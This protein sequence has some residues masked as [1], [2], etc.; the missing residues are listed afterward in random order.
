MFT[1]FLIILFA[2]LP[3]LSIQIGFIQPLT[4]FAPTFVNTKLPSI[5]NFHFSLSSGLSDDAYLRVRFPNYTTLGTPTCLFSVNAPRATN[6]VACS[7]IQDSVYIQ[8][9]VEIFPEDEIRASI[10]LP[11]TIPNL[12]GYTQL[13]ELSTVSSTD[14]N[15]AIIYDSNPGYGNLLWG[16]HYLVGQLFLEVLSFGTPATR[17]LQGASNDIQ[18]YIR[19]NKAFSAKL[20]RVL[21]VLDMPWKFGNAAVSTLKS[22]LFDVAEGLREP[23]D[24]YTP[25]VVSSINIVNDYV[26]EIYFEGTFPAGREFIMTIT[27]IINPI[28]ISQGKIKFYST[29]YTS[30][31]ALEANENTVLFTAENTIPITNSL[32]FGAPFIGPVKLY[33]N[34]EQYIK[35]SFPLDTKIQ[36]G[37]TLKYTFAPDNTPIPGTFYIAPTVQAQDGTN[38]QYTYGTDSITLT[39]LGELVSGETITIQTKMKFSR[40]QPVFYTTVSILVEGIVVKFGQSTNLPLASNANSLVTYIR[41]TGSE[42]SVIIIDSPPQI[43]FRLATTSRVSAA[44]SVLTIYT[45]QFI[46]DSGSMTCA[47]SSGVSFSTCSLTNSGGYS[48]FTLQSASGANAFPVSSTVDIIISGLNIIRASDHN[49]GI[50][51]FYLRLDKDGTGTQVQDLMVFAFVR[52][53]R[54]LLTNF[55]QYHIMNV[56]SNTLNNFPG[57]MRMFGTSTALSAIT[58]TSSQNLIITVYGFVTLAN[59][60][61]VTNEGEFPCGGSLEISCKLVKGNPTTVQSNPLDWD[62]VIITISSNALT[63]AFN[64]YIPQYFVNNSPQI[65]EFLVGTYDRNTR[66][67]ENLY[68]ENLY[69]ANPW[70]PTTFATGT[71]TSNNPNLYIDLSLQRAGVMVPT[72]LSMFFST[73]NT[74]TAY[75]FNTGAQYGAATVLVTAWEFW[76]K[77]STLLSPA[78]PLSVSAQDATV[79]LRFTTGDGSEMNAVIWPM[80]GSADPPKVFQV[81]Q[82]EMPYSLDIPDYVMYV[83]GRN[84]D[85]LYY[86]SLINTGRN[87]LSVNAITQITFNCAQMVRN[88]LN[89]FCTIQFT[90]NAKI[91]RQSKIKVKFSNAFV[92]IFGC[93]LSYESAPSVT[94][95]LTS[96]EFSCSSNLDEIQLSFNLKDRLPVTSYRFS[97]YGFDHGS[98]SS[99]SFIFNIWD[100]SYGFILEQATVN[101]FLELTIPDVITIDSMTYDYSNL[102]SISNFNLRFTLPRAIYPNEILQVDIGADLQGNNKNT[103]RLALVLTNANTNERI[104]ITGAL[105]N[106]V[107]TIKFNQGI[108]LSQGTYILS[109]DNLRTP[110]THSTDVI[111]INLKRSSDNV[112]VMQSK[113]SDFTFYPTLRQGASA[114]ISLTRSRFLCVG[115]YG[116]FQFTVTLS[117]SEID[118]ES[119]FYIHFPSYFLPAIANEAEQLDCRINYDPVVCDTHPDYPYRL[120]ITNSPFYLNPGDS[121]NLTVY[122]FI[123]PNSGIERS[124]LEDLFFAIDSVFNGSYS[125]Q[126]YLALPTLALIKNVFGAMFFYELNVGSTNVR[127]KVDH[128]LRVNTTVDIPLG[129]FI[130]VTFSKEYGNIRYLENIACQLDIFVEGLRFSNYAQTT[131]EITGQTVKFILTKNILKEYSLKL[132]IFKV[133][134]PA[135]SVTINPNKFVVGAFG[136]DENDV[137][138]ISKESLNSVYEISFI[139]PTYTIQAHDSKDIVLTRGTYSNDI[140]VGTADGSRIIQDVTIAATTEGFTFIPAIMNFYVGDISSTFKVGCGQNVKL[141]TYPL[142]FT[143]SEDSALDN[144]YGQLFDLRIEVVDTP[145]LITIPTSVTV[146]VG[147][148]SLPEKISLLNRP[149]TGVQIIIDIDETYFNGA[150]GINED[151]S[152]PSL[153]YS[154]KTGF[155]YLSFFSTP[156]ISTFPSSFVINLHLDGEDYESYSLSTNQ[157]QINIQNTAFGS[158][159]VTGVQN[160]VGKT[161]A[162]FDITPISEGVLLVQLSHDCIAQQSLGTIKNLLRNNTFNTLDITTGG[163]A[164][165]YLTIPMNSAGTPYTLNLTG[166][167]P[168]TKYNMYVYFENQAGET[169]EQEVLTFTFTTQGNFFYLLT[170]FC[171]SRSNR[172]ND[173]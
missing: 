74:P 79:Y 77:D 150:F 80:V 25:P 161:Q 98:G 54:N 122:G 72:P 111:V 83:T 120:R 96:S 27:D 12:P 112:F 70:Q 15:T 165:R 86:N 133:P 92:T 66:I 75:P 2:L 155:N 50:Y 124:S 67:Y 84:G 33:K 97:F 19:F 126:T 103:D 136:S 18:V 139:D 170:Y 115:C 144:A 55:N 154:I 81:Q 140:V 10:F 134:T 143:Q 88:T 100:A 107:L 105:K 137:I 52:P 131:C 63:N 82:V 91:D 37:S 114:S 68:I 38:I 41:G 28:A 17:N 172:Q 145:I 4:P 104:A 90:P 117:N 164:Q 132:T 3:K 26:L 71:T 108:F 146:P 14:T 59:Y 13:F 23:T 24:L 162:V 44:N 121:F 156:A 123:V 102:D 21:V 39:N 159:Q 7:T 147:G 85:M 61:Q 5:Y 101:Y 9:M 125:E 141:R 34:F 142:N 149:F 109:I 51:E 20:S 60:L 89:T 93:S 22:P 118:P 158:A 94:T 173:R 36:A 76:N 65:Y 160:S 16:P 166:L 42:D 128:I 95:T 69:T 167:T 113:Q 8:P 119:I 58:L 1:Y 168:E 53:A 45:N 6:Q 29:D 31:Y 47:S 116:E 151:Y 57:F 110:S 40:V 153:N 152:S 46:T 138:A 78:S 30:N 129:S 11:Q 73:P 130:T 157:I 87:A 106:Q 62:R 163:C 32:A 169:N 148:Y 135:Y 64:L 49:L 127:D 35:I 56:A 99:E 48:V 171:S 43:R